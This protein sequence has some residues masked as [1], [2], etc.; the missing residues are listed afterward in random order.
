VLRACISRLLERQ[1][2]WVVHRVR[3]P[4]RQRVRVLHVRRVHRKRI[5]SHLLAHIAIQVNVF[6][7]S[8]CDSN[9]FTSTIL[10]FL[11]VNISLA[12]VQQAALAVLQELTVPA[13]D[14]QPGQAV[15]RGR[16][17]KQKRRAV[18]AV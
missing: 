15:F 11:Q 13:S 18:Q 14:Y 8:H 2:V 5:R 4:L 3:T 7:S 9:Q 1:V 17:L 10:L 6:L 12:K 16:T